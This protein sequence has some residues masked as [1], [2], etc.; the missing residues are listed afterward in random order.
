MAR[1]FRLRRRVNGS[2]FSAYATLLEAAAT[3]ASADAGFPAEW[4][5]EH[6]TA[7]V[8]RRS[9]IECA[10]PL[11]SGADVEVATWVTD[12][13]RVR[14]RREY[15]VRL[16]GH[17]STV[18]TAHTD[19]VYV[20]RASGRPRRVP[21]EMIDAFMPEGTPAP[22]PRAPLELPAGG[23]DRVTTERI[24]PPEDVD[25]LGHVNN[26]R[27]F[28]YVEDSV[29]EVLGDESRARRVDLEYL[30]E[31]LSGDHLVCATWVIGRAENAID[32][33]TEIRRVPGNTPLT[34]A[35]GSWLRD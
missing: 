6:D 3:A 22:I 21:P 5:A 10:E 32:V 28:D 24:A 18:L 26:T 16:V 31:A 4:Y 34:R 19:W 29:R 8:I 9:A 11:A 35:R 23:A 17:E 30:V 7:W 20:E 27:Y 2:R 33:A 12:F 1:V 13:R 15:E 14:S 25:A